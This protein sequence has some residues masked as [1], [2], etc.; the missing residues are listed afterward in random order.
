ML[1]HTLVIDRFVSPCGEVMAILQPG[2]RPAKASAHCDDGA[3]R[4][5]MNTTP[6]HAQL[7]GDVQ[8]RRWIGHQ[9]FV[10]ENTQ[11]K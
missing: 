9:V 1:I 4:F 6:E 5:S 7:Q 11:P 2:Q 8:N 3:P 10:H